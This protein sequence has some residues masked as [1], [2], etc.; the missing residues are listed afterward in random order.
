MTSLNRREV[1]S[2]PAS[3]S[4]F[5]CRCLAWSL[6]ALVFFACNLVSFRLAM[7]Q[8]ANHLYQGDD[9][10]TAIG[11]SRASLARRLGT[12]TQVPG[13]GP[14]S[15]INYNDDD[16]FPTDS[17]M[18]VEWTPA[19][20]ALARGEGEGQPSAPNGKADEAAAARAARRQGS[21]GEEEARLQ[22]A[23][24]MLHEASGGAL[25]SDLVL[26]SLRAAQPACS[27]ACVQ[28]RAVQ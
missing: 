13:E 11:R 28:S 14:F 9:I 20:S 4:L 6:A 10:S 7:R 24:D 8:A 23:E 18:V 26:S 12:A 21:Q 22:F 19:S 17:T 1:M 2:K 3:R 5:S 25:R 27:P 16:M 15:P